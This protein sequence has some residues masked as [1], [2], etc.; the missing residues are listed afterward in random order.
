MREENLG[1]RKAHPVAHHLALRALAALEQERL[2]LAYQRHRR[3]V[4]LHGGA[5]GGGAEKRHAQHAAEY[6]GCAVR[7][8][9]LLPIR[10]RSMRCA[11]ASDVG[12]LPS[13]RWRA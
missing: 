9:R 7:G 13:D 12:L 3:D 4:A 8:A 6:K 2:T 11:V 10:V 1:Q 5:G